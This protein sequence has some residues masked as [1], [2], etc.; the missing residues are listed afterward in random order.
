MPQLAKGG[1]WVFGWVVVG[2]E[3]E[4]LIP[5]MAYSEYAF[6]ANEPVVFTLSSKRS[7]GFCLGKR[8]KVSSSII[9]S[10]VIEESVLSDHM[11]IVSP[12]MIDLKPG[13]RLL[14]VRGSNLALSFL[15][16]GPIVEEALNHTEI[17]VFLP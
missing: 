2:M 1:K 16:K 13:D 14:V 12:K 7:G 9:Y 4:I 11:K 15:R 5:P 10:R 3:R 17:E 6:Q 8:E